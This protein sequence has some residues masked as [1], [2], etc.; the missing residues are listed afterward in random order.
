MK[1]YAM[2][3]GL[4]AVGLS[5]PACKTKL[6]PGTCKKD[7]DCK[8][9]EKCVK[10][11]CQ[12][13][14]TDKDCGPGK[15]CLNGQCRKKPG[16]CDSTKDCPSGKVC[17]DHLCQACKQ[18]KECPSGKCEK[19]VCAESM[20]G[21]CKEDD[22]CKD[23]EVCKNGRC[24][25]AP[26][27]YSGPTL[28]ALKTV[29]FAFNK[30]A[31]RGQDQKVLEANAKYESDVGPGLISR[32]IWGARIRQVPSGFCVFDEVSHTGV[33]PP[34]VWSAQVG[35]LFDIAGERSGRVG[36]VV[37]AVG[38]PG[39]DVTMPPVGVPDDD[40]GVRR[41]GLF[42]PELELDEQL[43]RNKAEQQRPDPGTC[44]LD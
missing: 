27:P 20:T 31:I 35:Y 43:T 23:E 22:D 44:E 33:A 39:R 2:L 24:V 34:W 11:K 21:A 7:S 41:H 38:V 9:G 19:G 25:A 28:C 17:R 14:A 12:Q 30:A 40:R 4:I 16:Y 32:G 18:D 36:P 29:H 8:K 26:K 5:Q 15:Q 10:G 42:E 6:K 37:Q 1:K 13:C 3:I